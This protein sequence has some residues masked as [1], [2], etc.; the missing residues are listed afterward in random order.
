MKKLLCLSFVLLLAFSGCKKAQQTATHPVIASLLGYM[1]LDSCRVEKLPDYRA[2]VQGSAPEEPV[3]TDEEINAR[4]ETLI[5]AGEE[6]VPLPRAIVSEGDLVNYTFHLTYQDNPLSDPK[7]TH[8]KLG[9][10]TFDPQI[11]PQLIGAEVG[12]TYTFETVLPDEVSQYGHLAGKTAELH[13]T[14]NYIYTVEYPEVSDA[15]VQEEF[16]C[17]SVDAFYEMI[18]GEVLE[19][20]RAQTESDYETSLLQKVMEQT[21]FAIDE[22]QS[23]DYGTSIAVSG[24]SSVFGFGYTAETY[25]DYI[26]DAYGS[27]EAYYAQCYE[28]ALAN[29]QHFLTIGA[30][31]QQEGFTVSDEEFSA[32][33]ESMGIDEASITAENACYV[34]Y[35]VL[36]KEVLDFLAGA[37]GY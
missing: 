32:Q 5:Q 12:E 10:G 18:R 1:E 30:I 3:V 26:T 16:D 9:L 2:L 6:V 23:I 7:T 28:T 14:I 36:E 29:I 17:A 13:V 19:E 20:K 33:C 22:A 21:E 15:W 8:M 37:A 31:A 35:Y 11:E 34:R 24:L 27:D 4:I 25:G